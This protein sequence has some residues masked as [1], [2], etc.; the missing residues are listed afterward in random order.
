MSALKDIVE[1]LIA[2][3]AAVAPDGFAYRRESSVDM[4]V[5][6]R[7]KSSLAERYQRLTFAQK[8]NR[9]TVA[10]AAA[11]L[12]TIATMVIAATAALD[13]RETRMAI[14]DAQVRSANVTGNVER[15]RLYVERFAA[16]GAEAD[17]TRATNALDRIDSDLAAIR[18]VANRYDRAALTQI[19]DF[20]IG[21]DGYTKELQALDGSIVRRGAGPRTRIGADGAYRSGENAVDRAEAIGERLSATGHRL[22]E[23]S[24]NVIA[25]LI[26]GFAVCAALAILTIFATSR[27]IVRDISGTLVRLT[28]VAR[29]LSKGNKTT[30]VPGLER[31]DEIGQLA[32]SLKVFARAAQRFEAANLG[33]A[34]RAERELAQRAELEGERDVARRQKDAALLALARTFET[35][36]GRVSG[37]VA[38]AA[39]QLQTTA[40]DMA[41]AADRSTVQSASVVD[42]MERASQGVIAA[43]SASDEFA[44]SIGEIARQADQSAE[45]AR[46]A[47]R[48]AADA[49]GTISDLAT[50][51]G[52]VGQVVELIQTIARRTNLL[53]LNAS[54]EAARGG[55]AG[56]GFAVVASEVK[57]LANQTSRATQDIADQIRAMQNTTGASVA[58][59][60]SIAGQI[61]QME[62]SAIS[63]ATAVDQQ[64]RAGQELARNIDIAARG[65]DAV[66]E[67]VGEVRETSLATGNAAAQVL[68]S[69]N[70]L[71]GQAGML[72][73]KV[74]EFLTHI[75]AG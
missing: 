30:A 70:D 68:A 66:S 41:G 11:I 1:D 36:V 34:E 23:R 55:E 43:A 57:E 29:E 20:A 46:L 32:R 5:L 45:L 63:I 52:E 3:D 47:S 14:A 38:A 25:W 6:S 21:I 44:M 7:A 12:L 16:T 10:N 67:L 8:M 49:D 72:R 73:G 69:A 24:S 40:S 13:M 71:E 27:A 60:R 65:T 15:A 37:S 18:S 28:D 54:I 42:E 9:V 61:N 35:T 50:S 39:S 51:A 26:A 53:A 59:L 4:D 17:I 62:T 33:K 74:D 19:D 48:T 22:D 2:E 31:Q 75:R 58:A 56:R 64:T